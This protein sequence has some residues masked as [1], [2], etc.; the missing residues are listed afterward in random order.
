MS[1]MGSRR[2]SSLMEIMQIEA[3]IKQ[4]RNSLEYRHI[5]Q[6]I[7]K[8]KRTSGNAVIQVQNPEEMEKMVTVRRNSVESKKFLAIYEGQLEKY[9]VEIEEMEKTKK[10]L[11]SKLFA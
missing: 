4:M 9:S 5:Q 7:G 3:K 2:S 10:G 6:N 1:T 8:L 11:T